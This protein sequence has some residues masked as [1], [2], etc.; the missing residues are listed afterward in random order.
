MTN[1]H[2]WDVFIAALEEW[3]PKWQLATENQLKNIK[4][5]H[6]LLKTVK[7]DGSTPR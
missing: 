5:L 1:E 3:L 4:V 7:D 6:A 2:K